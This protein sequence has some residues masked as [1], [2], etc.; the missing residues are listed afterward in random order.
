[1][2]VKAL[3]LATLL[4]LTPALGWASD[5]AYQSSDRAPG[6]DIDIEIGLGGM[7]K[8]QWEGS[9]DYLLS[10]YPI[11]SLNFLSIGPLQIGGGPQRVISVRPDFG[12][13]GERDQNDDANLRGLGDVDAAFEFGLAGIFRQRFIKAEIG[14]R[15]GFGGHEGFV[16]EASVQGVVTPLPRLTLSVGPEVTF[17]DDEYM[18][19]YFGVSAAQAARSGLRQFN[20]SGGVKSAGVIANSRY[21]VND[22]VA[23]LGRASWHRL[24]GD[25]ADSPIIGRAGREDQFMIGAGMSYRFRLDLF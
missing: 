24:I 2:T 11:I 15:R 3:G 1:M 4:A 13:R 7:Y 19:T 16:G 23:I 22:H 21:Q 17:A 18:E 8:P 14:V 9:E 10:P 25:A 6:T 20:A 12:F 5:A